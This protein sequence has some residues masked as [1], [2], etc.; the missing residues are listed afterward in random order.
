MD[1]GVLRQGLVKRVREMMDNGAFACWTDLFPYIQ[2][3]IKLLSQ[4]TGLD[5]TYIGFCVIDDV[6]ADLADTE[7]DGWA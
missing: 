4:L 3:D 1:A 2:E 7:A 5:P 6:E